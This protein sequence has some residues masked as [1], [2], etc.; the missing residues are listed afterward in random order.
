MDNVTFEQFKLYKECLF[1][2][3]N[4]QTPIKTT[5]LLE[6]VNFMIDFLILEEEE[7][8]NDF[9]DKLEHLLNCSDNLYFKIFDNLEYIKRAGLESY[10]DDLNEMNEIFNKANKEVRK[11]FMKGINKKC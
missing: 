7:K 1:K 10:S 4:E 5:T 8:E 11:L 2:S 9:N 3:I 6:I